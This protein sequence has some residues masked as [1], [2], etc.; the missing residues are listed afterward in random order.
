MRA[1]IASD[2]R[3][4]IDS[5][6]K[7]VGWDDPRVVFVWPVPTSPYLSGML[8]VLFEKWGFRFRDCGE[9]SYEVLQYGKKICTGRE[10]LAFNAMAGATYKDMIFTKR[11]DEIALYL[12]LD[13]VGPCENGA[14]PVIYDAFLERTPVQ[15]AIPMVWVGRENRFLGKGLPFVREYI[16]PY[17]LSDL[18]EEAQS[19]LCC[20]A[21]DPQQAQAVFAQ[22]TA[23]LIESFRLG[24]RGIEAATREWATALGRVPRARSLADVPKI[25]LIG[26]LSLQFTKRPIMDTFAEQGVIAKALGMSESVLLIVSEPLVRVSFARAVVSAERQFDLWSHL[27]T[28]AYLGMKSRLRPLVSLSAA[29]RERRRALNS[30]LVVHYIESVMKRLRKLASPSLL[31][32]DEHVSLARLAALGH[33]YLSFNA[34]TESTPVVGRYLAAADSGIFDGLVSVGNF[35]CQPAQNALAVIRAI[36]DKNDIPFVGL[37]CDSHVLSPNQLRLLETLLMQARR[38]HRLRQI[39]PT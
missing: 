14:W 23:R 22:E 36:A 35:N 30:R 20:L 9:M 18:V 7:R 6:G 10:C 5:D 29:D 11:E 33:R 25:L 1:T 4:I 3:G 15:N 21:R 31:L 28:F 26:G 16:Y 37:D 34:F 32:Y 2:G 8:G 19:S 27:F 17:V 38:Q 12:C 13:Q 24:P 39:E